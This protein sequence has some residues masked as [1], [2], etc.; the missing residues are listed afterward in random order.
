MIG[1]LQ[2]TTAIQTCSQF[3]VCMLNFQFTLATH[4]AHARLNTQTVRR[5]GRRCRCCRLRRRRCRLRRQSKSC[6]R[7]NFSRFVAA[8]DQTNHRKRSETL[9]PQLLSDIASNHAIS[10]FGQKAERKKIGDHKIH[11]KQQQL[12]KNY[13]QKAHV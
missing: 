13:R 5:V 4:N 6:L 11:M 10:R 8:A 7:S 12:L 9:D 1:R 3:L 2:K